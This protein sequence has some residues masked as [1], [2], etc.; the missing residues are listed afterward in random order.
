MQTNECLK[1]P[2]FE[3]MKHGRKKFKEKKT[4]KMH[5]LNA[6]EEHD[7]KK[8]TIFYFALRGAFLP[9]SVCILTLSDDK[10]RI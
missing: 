2:A 9:L 8:K 6:A 10:K 3:T 4:R 7:Q 1:K 5:F